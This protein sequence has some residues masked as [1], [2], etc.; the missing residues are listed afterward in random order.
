MPRRGSLVSHIGHDL[1]L[2]LHAMRCRVFSCRVFLSPFLAVE[3]QLNAM[4]G[5]AVEL[6][7]A[8]DDLARQ[9]AKAILLRRDA[10]DNTRVGAQLSM[11]NSAALMPSTR[12]Q[13]PPF[14][15]WRLH[16][17]ATVEQHLWLWGLHGLELAFPP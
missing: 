1:A 3:E 10:D 11:E 16:A 12:Q 4:Q 2:S 14:A 5:K 6:R 7:Q 8:N 17:G 13:S 15:W 9:M